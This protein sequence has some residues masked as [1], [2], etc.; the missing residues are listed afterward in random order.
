MVPPLFEDHP[1][2]LRPRVHFTCPSFRGS[3]I[4]RINHKET[5]NRLV[6][7]GIGGIITGIAP[8]GIVKIRGDDA[9]PRFPIID[10]G[11][12]VIRILRLQHAGNLYKRLHDSKIEALIL[13]ADP[14]TLGQ[15]RPH[16]HKE[17]TQRI[18]GELHK[19]LTNAP[20][21]EIEKILTAALT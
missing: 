15:I 18:T 1:R 10:F 2:L 21:A 12:D 14:Q 5:G 9:R 3:L 8:E 13:I 6:T 19:T 20:I 17:V 16:L 11:I 4:A 7:H